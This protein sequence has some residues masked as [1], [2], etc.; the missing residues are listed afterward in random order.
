M[1]VRTRGWIIGLAV[2]GLVA[3]ISSSYM[4]Y[5]LVTDPSYTSFCDVNES[6]SCTQLY[7]SRY[8]SVAGVPVALGGVFWFGVVLLLS[9]A[10]ARAPE[11]SQPSVS[12][13]LRVWSL[14]GLAVVGYMAYASLFVLRTFCILCGVV[15]VAVAGIFFASDSGMSTSWRKLPASV[16]G[17]IGQLGR[18]PVGLVITLVFVG[19]MVATALSFPERS[20][21]AG[22]AG[23]AASATDRV[24]S[25]PTP[26]SME[27]QR[28]EF[29]RYWL[30]QPRVTLD[31]AS[32]DAPVVVLKFND[33]QCPACANTHFA[34]DPVFEKYASS[35]PGRVRLVLVDFPLDPAC[36]DQAPRGPHRAACDAA[37][38]SRLA[39]EVGDTEGERMERWLYSNQ[40][41]MS[42]ETIESALADIAGVDGDQLAARFDE[43][44][45]DVRAHIAVGASLPVEATPTYIINGVVLQGGLT[46]Q[47]FDQAIA[48]ELER[49]GNP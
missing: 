47:F 14:V 16:L 31:V 45:R 1:S 40:D 42:A 25:T 32:P 48:L 26:L 17:D 20:A 2:V 38:A 49:A 30:A 15:Y 21:L 10:A 19:T 34:Y 27:D 4:H 13:Y 23:G 7:E 18:R 8:G 39:R 41:T 35:H 12:T 36:N 11:A 22:F 44:I 46:P 28:S 37:V 9:F 3:A 24:S 6:V 33:F 5:Q 43:V 29:E